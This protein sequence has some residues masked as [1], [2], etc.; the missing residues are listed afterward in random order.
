MRLF[1]FLL[2]DIFRGS[3][4]LLCGESLLTVGALVPPQP[5]LLALAGHIAVCVP[6]AAPRAKHALPS[7]LFACES[8]PALSFKHF[9]EGGHVDEK[10]IARTNT[11]TRSLRHHNPEPVFV[12]NPGCCCLSNRQKFRN[13][14]RLFCPPT[15]S[16]SRYLPFSS[17][18]WAHLTYCISTTATRPYLAE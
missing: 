17:V 2:P 15:G 14:F 3:D 18:R 7:F 9:S 4:A 11:G 10:S 6:A 5:P 16:H 8:L 13:F 1:C 12:Q